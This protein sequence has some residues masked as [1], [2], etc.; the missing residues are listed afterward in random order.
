RAYEDNDVNVQAELADKLILQGDLE[1]GVPMLE[2]A[3]V[4]VRQNNDPWFIVRVITLRGEAALLQDDLPLAARL[5]KES[6]DD[7][8]DLHHT[9]ALLSAMAGLAGV[10]L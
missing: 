2:D 1:A 10:A 3:M 8:R 7:A 5:F 4:Y 9:L 6:I